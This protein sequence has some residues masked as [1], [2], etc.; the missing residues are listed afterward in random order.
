MMTHLAEQLAEGTGNV[1]VTSNMVYEKA[2]YQASCKAA[3]KAGLIDT[4]ENIKWLVET[5]LENPDIR[6]C[7][8]GRPIAFK[9]TK[10]ELDR[11]FDRLK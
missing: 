9:L 8:H 2:L 11:R 5:V 6:Y 4:P 7:P 3:M 10:S 1:A